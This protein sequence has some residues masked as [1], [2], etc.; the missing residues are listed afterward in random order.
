MNLPLP[1]IANRAVGDI[2]Q[3]KLLLAHELH[4]YVYPIVSV[5][6]INIIVKYA[7]RTI[8]ITDIT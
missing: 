8:F 7:Q 1:L 5:G 2:T 6:L 3:R 4:V